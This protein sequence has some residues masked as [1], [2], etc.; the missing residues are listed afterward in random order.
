MR[1]YSLLSAAHSLQDS[2]SGGRLSLKALADVVGVSS[3]PVLKQ[4]LP[5]LTGSG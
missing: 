4:H 2:D 1:V 5:G 3:G